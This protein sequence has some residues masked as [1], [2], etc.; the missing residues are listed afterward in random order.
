MKKNKKI[1][2]S[3]AAI[4]LVVALS[5]M[6]TQSESLQGRFFKIRRAAVQKI[7]HSDLYS[8]KNK[9]VSVVASAISSAV[10]SEVTSDVP[11]EVISKVPTEVS[12]GT[13]VSEVPSEVLS[14]ITSDVPSVVT[15]PVA[16]AVAVK[17]TKS[18]N[19][20]KL[21]SLTKKVLEMAA[22]KDRLSNPER[23]VLTKKQKEAILKLYKR[24]SRR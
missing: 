4:V 14:K 5:L 22:K 18:L 13:I 17:D 19:I 3:V 23:Y 1:I 10:P 12:T 15:S 21:S 24:N 8:Y 7:D 2:L 20:N 9:I 16:S 6:I 11:S